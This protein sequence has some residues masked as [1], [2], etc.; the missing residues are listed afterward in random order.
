MVDYSGVKVEG[1]AR[2]RSTLRKA[3]VDMREMRETNRLVAGV[4]VGASTAR[5]PKRTGRLAATVR[6]GA[7]QAAAIARAGNNR[8]SGVP[9]GPPIHWGWHTRHIKPNPFLSLTAQDTEPTWFGLYSQRVEALLDTIQG[10]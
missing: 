10:T 1:A 7:T 8:K 5:V 3:G 6:A 4:I 2:L 9:Y